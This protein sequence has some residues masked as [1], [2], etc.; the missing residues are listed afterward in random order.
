MVTQRLKHCVQKSFYRRHDSTRPPSGES[1]V[2][3]KKIRKTT[4]LNSITENYF[5]KMKPF[6]QEFMLGS[7]DYGKII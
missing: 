6:L 5:A 4:C 1:R 7:P 2:S 3:G